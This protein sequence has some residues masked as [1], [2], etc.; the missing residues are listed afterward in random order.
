MSWKRGGGIVEKQ[1]GQKRDFVSF[2]DG[3][4]WAWAADTRDEAGAYIWGPECGNLLT[5][6]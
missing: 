6:I 1:D 4:F 5:L 2:E 3:G